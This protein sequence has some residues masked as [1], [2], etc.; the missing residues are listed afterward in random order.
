MSICLSAESV[1]ILE[2]P[3][4][5]DELPPYKSPLKR[6]IE[7]L[8]AIHEKNRATHIENESNL[9]DLEKEYTST[10]SKIYKAEKLLEKAARMLKEAKK[11]QKQTFQKLSLAQRGYTWSKYKAQKSEQRL[12]SAIK[13]EVMQERISEWTLEKRRN[14]RE[15]AKNNTLDFEWIATNIPNDVLKII[16]SFIP[17]DVRMQMIN[18]F[19]H[20]LYYLRRISSTGLVNLLYEIIS[21]RKVGY[22]CKSTLLTN[23][24]H[25]EYNAYRKEESLVKIKFMMTLFEQRAPEFA[26]RFLKILAVLQK[27]SSNTEKWVVLVLKQSPHFAY[28][29]GLYLPH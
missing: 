18:H 23:G 17:Y 19:H 11:E 7:K 29:D 1:A 14:L 2:N 20:P 22:A 10:F 27:A 6:R 12:K 5:V 9:D 13:E 8:E 24:S 21:F 4:P 28:E 16:A 3:A 15:L 26:L 25:S